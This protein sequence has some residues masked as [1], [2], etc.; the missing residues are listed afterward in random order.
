MN[1]KQYWFPAKRYGWGWELPCTWQGWVF[2]I[3]W[4]GAVLLGIPLIIPHG[5]PAFFSFLG[6]MIALLIFVCYKKGEPPGW[7]WG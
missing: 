3:A 4:L 6:L 5:R 7:R 1:D 2:F